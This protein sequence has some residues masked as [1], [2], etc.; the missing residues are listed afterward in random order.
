MNK[1]FLS[2]LPVLFLLSTN[3]NDCYLYF[4]NNSIVKICT[5]QI[6]NLPIKLPDGLSRQRHGRQGLSST[7]N[8]ENFPK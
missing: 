5:L 1:P 8:I 2:D 3:Q 4:E 6:R 7:L